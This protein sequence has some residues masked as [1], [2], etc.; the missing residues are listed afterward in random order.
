MTIDWNAWGEAAFARAQREDKPVLLSISAVWCH[1]CHVMD[2]TSYSDPAVIAAINERFVA[3][4]VDNDERPDVNARYNMGGWPTTAFL[5]PDGSI[6]TGATYLPPR[7]MERALREISEYYRDRKD[8]ISERAA[9][10]R[11]AQTSYVLATPEALHPA[12]LQTF[13]D[14]VMEDY[15]AEFGGFGEDQKFPQPEL[16][17]YLLARWR[18]GGN[19]RLY[20]AVAQTMRAMSGGGMYDPIE[21]GYFR[22][23]TTRD[24]SVPHFEK[25]AEDHG[26]L[27]RV[28]AQL[29][30]WAPSEVWRGDLHRTLAYVNGVLLDPHTQLYAGSQDADET[31]YTLDAAGRIAH[32]APFVDRRSYSN[33]TAGIA[34][35][36]AWCGTALAEPELI[37]QAER[38][39][40]A[41][42]ESA[43]EPDGLLYHVQPPGETPRVT[44]LLSDQV[45]YIRALIDTYEASGRSD[46]LVRAVTHAD[47][48]I[49]AFGAGDGGFYD[50]IGT[51]TLGRLEH[52]DRPLPDNGVMAE[53][54]LRLSVLLHQPAYRRKAEQTLLLYARTFERARSFAAT[55]ARALDRYLAPE[56]N[57]RIEGTDRAFRV[58]AR[59]LPTPFAALETGQEGSGRGFV[60]VGTACAAPVTQ[61]GA[62]AAAYENL[63]R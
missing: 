13:T 63:G 7:Q 61:P 57:V 44:G 20:D 60:C 30:L 22:Y 29:E 9:Q 35:A 31:Y 50:R 43:R 42:H 17:E 52:A 58:A 51:Q 28:L 14:L 19:V 5:T 26:G 45:A 34:G 38:T 27:L 4:R 46:L 11:G 21:G 62:L 53:N 23:S 32:G 12:L 1:W 37:A 8:E 24:Y 6:L 54:L 10:I 47:A 41:L 25:M 59:R 56:V 2:D 33:W 48:T 15:D 55:Y 39:L 49:A 36:L 18:S 40:D 16:L 3:I